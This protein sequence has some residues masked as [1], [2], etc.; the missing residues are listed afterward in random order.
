MSKN[1][2]SL[3]DE[4]R[5]ANCAICTLADSMKDC[6]RC[7]FNIGLAFKTLKENPVTASDEQITE[8]KKAYTRQMKLIVNK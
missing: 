3:P 6:K 8:L 5:I 4:M 7:Q 1:D 2:T